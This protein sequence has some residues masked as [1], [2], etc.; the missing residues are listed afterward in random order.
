MI[1]EEQLDALRRER[2][3][4]LPKNLKVTP[5]LAAAVQAYK[6]TLIADQDYPK[7]EKEQIAHEVLKILGLPVI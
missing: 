4:N 7:V 1:T 2:V 5:G 3:M 6:D